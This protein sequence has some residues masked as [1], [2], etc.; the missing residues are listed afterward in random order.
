MFD[1]DKKCPL[2]KK[3][4]IKHECQWFIQLQGKNPNTGMPTD[5]PGCAVAWMPILLIETASETR[6]ASADIESFRN[7]VAATVEALSP[8]TRPRIEQAKKFIGK[9]DE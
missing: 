5:E 3:K 2:L 8:G 4:C 7:E 6:K 1:P 9:I